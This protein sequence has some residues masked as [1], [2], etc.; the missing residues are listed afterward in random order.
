MQSLS[1]S[2]AAPSVQ[3]HFKAAVCS[4]RFV[5]DLLWTSRSISY[6]YFSRWHYQRELIFTP[7]VK[8]KRYIFSSGLNAVAYL[9]AVE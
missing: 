9:F 6:I 3:M 7:N 4:L 5:K 1:S 2:E 8:I